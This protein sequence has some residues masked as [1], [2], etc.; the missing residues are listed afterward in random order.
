[1][2]LKRFQDWAQKEYS[3]RQRLSLIIPALIFFCLFLPVL[4]LSAAVTT[5]RSF[6]WPLLQW[7]YWNTVIGPA[8]LAFGAFFGLWTVRIQFMIGLGTPSPL[9]PTRKLITSGPYRFCR[10]PMVFGVFVAYSGIAIWAASPS[11]I[12]MTLIFMAGASLYIKL[13]EEKELE[14]RF[15]KEYTDYKNKVPFILPLFRGKL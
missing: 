12:V 14:M 10:N 15:G 1:M 8:G 4:F 13:I 3:A 9:M 7:G 6:K 11:G 2:N 5:D